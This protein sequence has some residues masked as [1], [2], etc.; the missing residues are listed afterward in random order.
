[1]ATYIEFT[2][3]RNM[4]L[5]IH[6]WCFHIQAD[7]AG[8]ERLS[9]EEKVYHKHVCDGRAAELNDFMF[10]LPE[11]FDKLDVTAKEVTAGPNL[12]THVLG[13]ANENL[14]QLQSGEGRVNRSCF[15]CFIN[16]QCS[17]RLFISRA[18]SDST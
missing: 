1:M 5:Q 9:D 4:Y 10:G 2:C 3:Y 17:F 8:L 14:G 13:R 16:R 11:G 6:R 15:S 7:D 12:S 18:L